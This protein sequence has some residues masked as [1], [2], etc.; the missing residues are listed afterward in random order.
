MIRILQR[1]EEKIPDEDQEPKNKAHMNV[2][3]ENEGGFAGGGFLK[4]DGSKSNN[5]RKVF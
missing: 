2:A 4:I 1:D 5:L 3:P